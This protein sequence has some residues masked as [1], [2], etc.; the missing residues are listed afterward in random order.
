M[1]LIR[2]VLLCPAYCPLCIPVEQ[3]YGPVERIRTKLLRTTCPLV[4]MAADI[5]PPIS[6]RTYPKNL[7]PASAN[8]P[9]D[10]AFWRT[11]SGRCRFLSYT[12]LHNSDIVERIA[13]LWLQGSSVRVKRNGRPWK[14]VQITVCIESFSGDVLVVQV[15]VV[16]ILHERSAFAPLTSGRLWIIYIDVSSALVAALGECDVKHRIR[17]AD[18]PVDFDSWSSTRIRRIMLRTVL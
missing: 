3:I 11:V 13:F 5:Q 17:L 4:W 18:V 16:V 14:I 12:V 10:I 9:V 6:E 7:D 8:I 15:P 1:Y 2:S